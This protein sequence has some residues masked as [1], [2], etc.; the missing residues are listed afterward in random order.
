[1][2]SLAESLDRLTLRRPKNY[3]AMVGWRILDSMVSSLPTGIMVAAVYVLMGPIADPGSALDVR[4]LAL[5]LVALAAQLALSYLSSRKIYIL[6]C[7]GTADIVLEARLAMGEKLRRLP[8][9]FYSERDAGD[10]T[11]VLLRDYRTVENYGGELLSQAGCILARLAV[12][13]MFLAVFDVRM[14]AATLAVVPLALPFLYLGF[15][16]LSRVSDEMARALRESDARSIEYA[17]GIRTLKAFGLAGEQFAAL[18]RS[19]DELRRVSIKKEA[20]S[21]PV[22][23]FGRLVLSC[24]IGVVMAAG[25]ALL[26]QGALHPFSFMV[27]L[28][29]ALNLYEPVISLF[30]FLSDFSHA[31]KAARRIDAVLDEPE[32]SEPALEKRR[33]AQGFDYTF[34]EVVFGYGAPGKERPDADAAPGAKAA[35]GAPD[36]VLRGLSLEA[37]QG[38]MTAL[39]GRSGSGKSTIVRLMARFWDPRAGEVRLG[40]VPLK[41][42]GADALLSRVSIVF[43]DVYL[44]QDTIAENIRMGREGATDE[45]VRD[46]ARRAA[47]L[48]FIE[49]LPQGFDTVVGEGGCTLSGGEKQRISIAR[50]LLKDAPIVLLDEATASLDP[51]NEVLVQRAVAELVRDK[52]VVVIAHRL[53]SVRSAARIVVVDGG[54][55][56]ESG[57]HDEL[58]AAGGLYA[59]MWFEQQR[60]GEWR[61]GGDVP[62]P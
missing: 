19:F 26:S 34:E 30:Y 17:R 53:R 62:R 3:C 21:R 12:F 13:S 59:G 23:V 45:E 41:R 60:A 33:A 36:D 35:Q 5:C 51:Q 61:L 22:A 31:D 10:L 2:G 20:A 25:T 15:R 29:V 37:P 11:S 6:T 7:A 46:A 14:A 4:A 28:L 58:V 32:L 1:M 42:M 8:M 40:G 52:T 47:C 54:V 48:E 38:G 55:V 24:G 16:G 50:A 43:Q 49:R 18:E 39:V 27:F 56:A 9:G 57:T 44:F